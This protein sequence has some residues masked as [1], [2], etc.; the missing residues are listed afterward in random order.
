[1]NDLRLEPLPVDEV[2]WLAAVVAVWEDAAPPPTT[3]QG[4]RHTTLHLGQNSVSNPLD[5]NIKMRIRIQISIK[6]HLDPDPK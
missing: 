6:H 3:R 1:M 4:G 5:A 2:E